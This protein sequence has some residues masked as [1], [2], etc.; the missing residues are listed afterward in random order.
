MTLHFYSPPD[1]NFHRILFSLPNAS[2]ISKWTLS[3]NCDPGIFKDMLA[4]LRGEINTDNT[5]YKECSVIFNGMYLKF[6]IIYNNSKRTYIMRVLNLWEK[7]F[8]KHHLLNHC[9]KTFVLRLITDA[10][11][12]NNHYTSSL[13]NTIVPFK[14]VLTYKF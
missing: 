4:F 9:R 3:V 2:S 13:N 8:H 6:G 1:Y 10:S 12:I 11:S 7:I 5:E 14:Y